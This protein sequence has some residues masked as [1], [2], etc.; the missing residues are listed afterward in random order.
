MDEVTKIE[1]KAFS[2]EGLK[3]QDGII[4]N[5]VSSN[6]T[7][8]YETL[9]KLQTSVK[10]IGN[11]VTKIEETVM[12]Q[13]DKI[14]DIEKSLEFSQELVDKKIADL[15]KHWESKILQQ[16]A[17][18]KEK[19]RFLKNKLRSLEDRNKRNILRVEGVTENDNE[20]WEE[21]ESKVKDLI[22]ERMGIDEELK[23]E[24]A[25]RIGK[26]ENRKKRAIIFKLE[27]WKQKEIILKKTNKLKNTG[28][29]I[30]EDFSDETMLIRKELFPL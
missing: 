9:G 21:S 19:S 1:I 20:T 26:K 4:K 18:A 27:S 6:S 17:T 28:L 25:H 11:R 2:D 7:F 3:K 15:D 5:Y 8:I 29:Y 10:A 13:G 22:K 12:E 30:N 23:I 24:R 14:K 16:A